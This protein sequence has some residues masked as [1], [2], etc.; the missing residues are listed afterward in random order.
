[1]EVVVAVMI[2]GVI[3]TSIITVMNRC[4]GA[5]IDSRTNM[6]AFEIARNNMEKL[7]AENKLAE[8]IE[9]GISELN[10]DIQWETLIE[11]FTE[12]V[13]GS[14]WLQAAC[15]ATYTD[16]NG[17][18]QTVEFKHWLSEVSPALQKKLKAQ[19]EK[20]R[21]LMAQYAEEMGLD[22][23]EVEIGDDGEIKPKDPE[24]G[25]EGDP[26]TDQKP[27]ERVEILCGYTAAEL[28]LMD[29]WTVIGWMMNGCPEE[30]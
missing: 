15:S 24:G 11:T 2:I 4:I 16:Q 20:E 18:L 12:P 14:M 17:E 30:E 28:E 27:E 8:K 23:D 13:T 21:Q 10:P 7:L 1:M 29:P 25:D 26:G 22:P 19:D 9:F 5:A 3:V 6:Q